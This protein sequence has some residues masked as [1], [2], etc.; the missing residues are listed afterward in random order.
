MVNF[1]RQSEQYRHLETDI[2]MLFCGDFNTV[3]PIQLTKS[4]N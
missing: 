2:A 4:A 1:S 3:N